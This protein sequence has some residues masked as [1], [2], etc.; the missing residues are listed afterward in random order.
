MY[1]ESRLAEQTHLPPLH[2][3]TPVGLRERDGMKSTE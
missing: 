1:L 3:N 2:A